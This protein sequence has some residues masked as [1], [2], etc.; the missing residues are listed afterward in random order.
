MGDAPSLL[1]FALLPFIRQ[2]SRVNKHLYRNGAYSHLRHWLKLHLESRIFA[3]AMF[4]YPLW[5]ESGKE[6]IL[7]VPN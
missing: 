7:G 3:K 2:F 6:N 1:D 5:L 4:K